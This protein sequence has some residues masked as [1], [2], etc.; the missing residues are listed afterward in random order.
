MSLEKLKDSIFDAADVNTSA[1][2]KN[3][4]QKLYEFATEQIEKIVVSDADSSMVYGIIQVNN[5][6]ETILLGSY[7]SIQWLKAL[8][9]SVDNDFHSDDDYRN[10][11]SMLVAQAQ[12]AGAAT[13]T[14]YNRIAMTGDAIYYDLSSPKWEA[15]KITRGGYEIVSLNENTPIFSR[16]QQQSEQVRPKTSYKNALGQLV[17]LFRIQPSDSEIFKIHMITLFLEKYPIPIMVVHGEH[18]SAKSTITK[19]VAGIVDPS[20]M[21][22]NS[23]PKNSAE[24]ALYFNNRY[25]SN[26]DNVSEIKQET[27]DMMC[28]AITGEGFTKRKLYTDS[29]EIIWNYKRKNHPKWHCSIFGVSRL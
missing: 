7:E 23:I 3:L 10:V 2:K 24:L 26:F 12:Q 1:E 9:F 16:K 15:V 19:S 25:V 20:G 27:S 13:V 11:L 8:Y 28:R 17:N 29:S 18:G 22:I 21:N 4:K 6:K 5:H 14:I